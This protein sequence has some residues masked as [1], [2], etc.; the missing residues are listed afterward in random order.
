[1]RNAIGNQGKNERQRKK[2]EQDHLQ[3]FLHKK[4]N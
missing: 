4:C 1:M 2:S 3:H